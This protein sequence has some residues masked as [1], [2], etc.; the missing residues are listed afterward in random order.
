M[1]CED[2]LKIACHVFASV[3]TIHRYALQN[4]YNEE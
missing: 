3:A 2:F 1:V 4:L